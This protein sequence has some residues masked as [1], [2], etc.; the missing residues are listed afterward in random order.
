MRKL[1]IFITIFVLYEFVMLSVLQIP[2]Y[3]NAIFNYN[4]CAMYNFKYFLL[5]LMLPVLCGLVIWWTPEFARMLCPNKCACDK[6]SHTIKNQDNDSD[7]MSKQYLEKLLTSA[8][9]VG[10]HKFATSHPKTRETLDN[11]INTLTN[12]KFAK[13][14]KKKS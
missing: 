4:F 14:K 13:T 12:T 1:K 10:I 5:C 11:I 3:C 6:T 7:E 8:I 2:T 9:M